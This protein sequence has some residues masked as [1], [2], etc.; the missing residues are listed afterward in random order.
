MIISSRI[1]RVEESAT[2]KSSKRA[3]T[4]IS[5]GVD[6]INFTLGEPDFDTPANIIEATHQAMKAGET[7]YS[8]GPG[9]PEL[10]TAIAAKL[11][12]ENGIPTSA[13][14][15]MVT[16]GAK[17]AVFEAI[18]TLIE[19]GDEVLLFDPSWVS[20]DACIKMAGGKTIWAETDPDK[21]YRPI[22]GLAEHI[23]DKTKMIIVNTPCNPTGAV[24]EKDQLKE[25]ADLATDHNLLV[26]S[27]E[28]YEKITYDKK[29]FS[30]ASLN[31]MDERTITINGFSKA[32]AMT[33]W[34]LGYMA[35][36]PQI[37]KSLEKMQ[38]HTVSNVTTFIQ[39][40]G[41]EALKGPQDEL[42][43]MQAAFRERRDV[44][45]DGLQN[46]GLKC[47]M[48]DGAFYAYPDVG[49]FGTGE[50]IADRLLEEAYV[51]VS[52]GIAFGESGRNKIRISYATSVDRIKEALIRMEKIFE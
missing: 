43:K 16:P 52:P 33:G 38:S 23:T 15:I 12:S 21:N 1:G 30:I 25:I 46:L 13:E 11:R 2:I 31:D 8:A 49:E 41:V 6:V 18:M 24:Y 42:Y 39:Y 3:R 51:A 17:F 47:P 10:R 26:I 27:D 5:Q 35:A 22:N 28:I 7:H 29:N 37:F 36:P 50:E 32:Y 48:P 9:I 45:V 44:L 20:Y 4:L 40:G 14:D 34:R 19:D